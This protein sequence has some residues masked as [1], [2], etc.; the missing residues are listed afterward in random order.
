MWPGNGVL[1][2]PRILPGTRPNP[3]GE[4]GE[5]PDSPRHPPRPPPWG[6]KPLETYQSSLLGNDTGE[7]PQSDYFNLPI[8]PCVIEQKLNLMKLNEIRTEIDRDMDSA[9]RL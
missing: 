2:S 3:H 4:S 6:V 9:V 8:D 5:S 1:G 7:K